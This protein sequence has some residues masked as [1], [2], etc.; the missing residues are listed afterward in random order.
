MIKIHGYMSLK[1]F[2]TNECF[3]PQ[4]K[5]NFKTQTCLVI[6]KYNLQTDH[7]F[8]QSVCSYHR[9]HDDLRRLC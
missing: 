9:I 1:W 7:N 3:Y 8:Q 4:E 6:G 2:T 5:V